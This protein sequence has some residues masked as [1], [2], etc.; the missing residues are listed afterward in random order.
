MA[1]HGI[2]RH[3]YSPFPSANHPLNIST[4]ASFNIPPSISSPP[5]RPHRI[6]R[7]TSLLP[8]QRLIRLDSLV[9]QDLVA[10]TG[11]VDEALEQCQVVIIE[12][13]VACGM[14]VVFDN[15]LCEGLVA[16]HLGD[17]GAGVGF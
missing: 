2:S 10:M 14:V 12:H 16:D 9:S 11:V 5:M 8:L 3:A 13:A 17:W 1:F 7:K 15:V 4:S 6:S